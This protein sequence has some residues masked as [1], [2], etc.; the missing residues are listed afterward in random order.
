VPLAGVI[1]YDWN[2]FV[3]LVLFWIENIVTGAFY[4]PR[5]LMA[6]GHK[7]VDAV[8]TGKPVR[9]SNQVVLAVFFCF[10]YGLF[11]FGH[12]TFVFSMFDDP[13]SGSSYS[14]EDVFTIIDEFNLSLAI[15]ALAISH[16]FSFVYNYFFNGEYK[17]AIA[18]QQMQRPYHRVVILHL[19]IILGGFLVSFL[20]RPLMGLVAL[21][22]IK[23]FI[24]VKAHIMEHQG[25]KMPIVPILGKK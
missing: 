4:V 14:I 6:K 18:A 8:N 25:K 16:G 11:C 22:V 20:D 2:P 23:I 3:L 13:S 24:D 19:A 9:S 10:H 1:W 5:I 12:G 7:Q 17:K 21:I 15:I